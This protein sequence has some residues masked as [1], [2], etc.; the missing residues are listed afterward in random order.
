MCSFLFENGFANVLPNTDHLLLA[1]LWEYFEVH[2]FQYALNIHLIKHTVYFEAADIHFSCPV[3]CGLCY[4]NICANNRRNH[5]V[6]TSLSYH[7]Y[8]IILLAVISMEG[9]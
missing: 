9:G 1:F 8:N 6:V 5:K 7:H 2:I 3:F 4:K